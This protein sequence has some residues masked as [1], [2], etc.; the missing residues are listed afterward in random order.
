MSYD[1]QPEPADRTEVIRYKIARGIWNLISGGFTPPTV[2]GV[3]VAGIQE[4]DTWA[5]KTANYTAAAGALSIAFAPAADFEGSVNGIAWSGSAGTA[6]FQGAVS[7]VAQP[8]NVL[9]AFAVT[10][11]AGTFLIAEARPV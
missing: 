2:N 10:R 5:T 1:G 8:G 4:V 6:L 9:P 11:S 3:T 7:R